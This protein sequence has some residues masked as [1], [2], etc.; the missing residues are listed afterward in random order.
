M[1]AKVTIGLI[2]VA[3]CCIMIM[4]DLVAA[5]FADFT[6]TITMDFIA[7]LFCRL[8][9]WHLIARLP[10]LFFWTEWSSGATL[11]LSSSPLPVIFN[12]DDCC[13]ICCSN[14]Y[15]CTDKYCHLDLIFGDPGSCQDPF[16]QGPPS[17]WS[18]SW[19]DQSILLI[20][21]TLFHAHSFGSFS[22]FPVPT[23]P[24]LWQWTS[25]K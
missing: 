21:L 12:F 8:H 11:H 10:L 3:S 16:L 6:A 18:P 1:T 15:V 2:L 13:A 20:D 4:R 9:Y 24:P 7:P 5:A 23:S 25:I 19:C 14:F 22:A 17:C